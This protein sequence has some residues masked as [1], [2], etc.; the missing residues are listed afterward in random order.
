MDALQS[1][2]VKEWQ[3]VSLP[4]WKRI[5]QECIE[6]KD[7]DRAK[8]AEWMLDKVLVDSENCK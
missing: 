4:E 6:K 5:L 2:M 8:Y 1:M 3:R 7:T